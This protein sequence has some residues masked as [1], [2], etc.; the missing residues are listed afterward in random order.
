MDHPPSAPLKSPLIASVLVLLGALL[1]LEASSAS[2]NWWD[3]LHPTATA[4]VTQTNNYSRT[5]SEPARVDA[6]TFEFNLGSTQ[7]RQL[8]PRL[9]LL[10][11]GEAGSLTVEKYNLAGSYRFTGRATLQ[12]KF[13]LG[14]QA[15]VL[16]ATVSAGHKAARLDD[17]RGWTTEAGLQLSKR[18]LT[19]LRFAAS[20]AWLEHAA[21][22]DTFDLHQQSYGVE[23]L[24]DVNER[25]S[26]RASASRLSGDIVANAT[27][28]NW[29]QALGGVAGPVVQQYYAARPW[30]VT[31]LY[32]SGWVS[33]NVEADV[34]LWSAALGYAIAKHTS[35]ELRKSAAYVVN[36]I[37]ISYPNDSWSLG[38]THRF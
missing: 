30:R 4:T 14:P 37:G 38:L 24:W 15:T 12:T 20:A 3:V 8:T 26:L 16:Q 7:A 10:V 9:L 19:N 17:D 1:P 13:G 23:A 36:Q 18:V 6:T 27:W 25:W 35:M 2:A 32:G 31:N 22:R 29:G 33:Y 28:S 34:D 21:R 5:S 11:S